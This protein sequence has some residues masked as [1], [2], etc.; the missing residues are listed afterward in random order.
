MDYHDFGKVGIYNTE[1]L[2]IP[3]RDS[4][5]ERLPFYRWQKEL[6]EKQFHLVP[7]KWPLENFCQ[8]AIKFEC[9]IHV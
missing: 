5:K 4:Q 7:P 3:E 6:E 1:C 9:S 8:L 2:K